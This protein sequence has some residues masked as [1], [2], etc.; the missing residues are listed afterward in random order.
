MIVDADCACTYV[1]SA[2]VAEEKLNATWA[3]ITVDI[4]WRCGLNWT[5]VSAEKGLKLY[6]ECLYLKFIQA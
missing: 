1:H 6:F 5:W 4:S 3:A 2:W